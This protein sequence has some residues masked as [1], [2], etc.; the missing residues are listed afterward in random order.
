M[1]I[2]AISFLS[3]SILY[4][5]GLF[6]LLLSQGMFENG[7][8]RGDQLYLFLFMFG[9]AVGAI[10]TAL[11]FDRTRLKEMLGLKFRPSLWWLWAMLI[12]AA[13]IAAATWIAPYFPG[14]EIQS[15]KEAFRP[16][17]ESQVS[18][19]LVD[20]TLE[21]LPPF[22]VL[23]LLAMV[24]GGIVNG[25]LTLS[26]ELGW[27]GYFWSV[28]RPLGFWKASFVTGLLWGLWHAP[29]IANG[30][31]FPG[32]PVLGP[33]MMTLFTLALSPLMGWLRDR[34][35]SVFTG[36]IFHGV[37]NAIAPISVMILV[38]DNVFFNGIIGWPGVAVLVLMTLPLLFISQQ[39]KVA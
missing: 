33:V 37:L 15:T 16:I 8:Q 4:S 19:D 29:I 38:T 9:P 2:R 39:N 20:Q 26:E 34:S 10:I 23:F 6:G 35:G 5:W 32:Q 24:T 12:P 17:I 13:A 31:N 14:V 7:F 30:Y 28:V 36:S 25:V 27:R 18:A 22:A 3:I 21:Q 11:L 1:L